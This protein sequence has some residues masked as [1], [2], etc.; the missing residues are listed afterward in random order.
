ISGSR[1]IRLPQH[2]GAA[3]QQRLQVG[4]DLRP[5]AGYRRDES[6]GLAL[7]AVGYGKPDRRSE[8][9]QLQRTQRLAL[10]VQLGLALMAPA[11][12]QAP[13]RLGFEDLPG[14]GDGAPGL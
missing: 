13:R 11:D 3:L 1:R 7:D 14:I 9:L 2:H 12:Y 10:G 4:E 5:A 6:G 8:P